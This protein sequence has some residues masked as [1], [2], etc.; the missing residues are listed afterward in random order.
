MSRATVR[1]AVTAYLAANWTASPLIVQNRETEPPVQADGILRPWVYVE[2]T[3]NSVDQ[4]SIGS[5]DRTDNRWREDGLVLFHIM[6]PIGEGLAA[7]DTNAD[8]LIELF[9]GVQLDP[10][11][12]FRDITSD[13]GGPGDQNGNYHRVS[14]AIDWVRN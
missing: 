12:E 6:T 7:S 9:K 13:I 2:V 5:S 8:A 14:I 10:D 4:W 3:F 11:I 1:A